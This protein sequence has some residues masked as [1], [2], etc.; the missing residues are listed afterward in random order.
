M[1][2]MKRGHR[3]LAEYT[4]FDTLSTPPKASPDRPVA[5]S[6]GQHAA[7]SANEWDAVVGKQMSQVRIVY[8]HTLCAAAGLS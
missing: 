1:T 8:E 7:I 6:F 2:G 4:H 5:H 3:I